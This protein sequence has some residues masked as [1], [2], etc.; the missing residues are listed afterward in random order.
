MRL[1]A[2]IDSW[3]HRILPAIT[4]LFVLLLA[5]CG[6]VSKI[7]DGATPVVK[8]KTPPPITVREL[9]GIP[10]DKAKE[11]KEALAL[12]AGQHDIGIV[13][14]A[15]PAGT[16]SLIGKF[17]GE[18]QAGV[19]QI[20]Y[21]WELRDDNGVLVDTISASQTAGPAAG[22]DAWVSVTPAILQQIAEATSRSVA[23]KLAKLGYTT[24]VG[25]LVMP[26][27]HTFVAAGPGAENEIDLETLNGP[28]AIAPASETVAAV[29]PEP[30]V[31]PEP[32]PG[33]ENSD[34]VEIRVVAVVA[35]K[36][37]PGAGN[38]E[39]TE[40]MRR[41][42]KAAGWPVVNK[43]RA[44]ALIIRGEVEL[45]KAE[46]ASQRVAL[47]WLVETPQGR[48]LGDV[49]QANSVPAGSLDN[50]WGGAAQAVADAA[51]SGIF[52]IIKRYR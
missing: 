31:P 6:G 14:G 51:A 21:S 9:T 48:S 46:G 28:S 49:K 43:P 24:R 37:A 4:I 16:Y 10:P 45:S 39:L 1:A 7:D 17:H 27:A 42:L 47:L 40:A 30:E 12:S 22:K 19:A 34:K 29:L 44:D 5:A 36:G 32:K 20:T 38:V 50:G 18:V 13:E 35:V 8:G 23:E 26:P 2:A 33:A 11:L 25:A 3:R 52:D 41:T 15:V